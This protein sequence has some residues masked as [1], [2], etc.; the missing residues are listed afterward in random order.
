MAWVR[1][2]LVALGMSGVC[3]ARA[4]EITTRTDHFHKIKII[5]YAYGHIRF[6]QPS[7]DVTSVSILDVH[8]MLVD[9]VGGVS[10]LNQAE[11]YIDK[12]RPAQAVLRYERALRSTSGFWKELVRVRL[13]RAC[14]QAGHLDKTVVHWLAVL[15]RDPALAAELLPSSIPPTRTRAVSRAMFD[16]E[17]ALAKTTDKPARRLMDLL[18]YSIYR[19]LGDDVADDLATRIAV[20]PLTGPIATIPAYGIKTEALRRVFEMKRNREVLAGLDAAIEDCPETSLPDL[21]LLKGEVLCATAR[22]REDYIRSGWA[23][24]RVPIHFPDDPRAARGLLG[25]AGVHEKIDAP[26]KA[27]ELLR[28]CLALESADAET[29]TAADAALKRLTER[30]GS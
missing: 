28:E 26:E 21:L 7:G 19:R 27:V 29:R 20:V 15:R 10:D 2:L 11:I 30:L 14:D 5:D 3:A 16:L 6:R 9:T 24:M 4:D 8:A 12:G 1:W 22:N 25:A 23:F 18:Q 17:A 13:L